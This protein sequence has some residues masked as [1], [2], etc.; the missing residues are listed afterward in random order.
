M[1]PDVVRVRAMPDYA[2][3]AEFATGEV[4]RL[5]MRPY[6]EFPAFSALKENNLFMRARV[7]HGTVE[8]N[9]E[10]DLSPDT[11]YMRGQANKE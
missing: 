10:I 2:I 4:R 3:V 8:W 9:D 1:T 7:A 6:L 5:D 11:I